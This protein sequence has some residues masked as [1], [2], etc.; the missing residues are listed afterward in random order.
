MKPESIAQTQ[1]LA[2]KR[3]C[4]FMA[5]SF[6][7]CA[8]ASFADPCNWH[9]KEKSES[10]RS[11][12]RI[13]TTLFGRDVFPE[14]TVRS[15]DFRKASP[16]MNEIAVNQ[17]TNI[18]FRSTYI[19]TGPQKFENLGPRIGCQLYGQSEKV[20]FADMPAFP[21]VASPTL[22]L[23][24]FCAKPFE[25]ARLLSSFDASLYHSLGKPYCVEL[26]EPEQHFDPFGL[27]KAAIKDPRRLPPWASSKDL[28]VVVI[29]PPG[30][31]AEQ[32]M[33]D[34][35]AEITRVS[36][37]QCVACY[38]Q[39]DCSK[40]TSVETRRRQTA[41][42]LPVRGR[43]GQIVPLDELKTL[44]FENDI[45][46]LVIRATLKKDRKTVKSESWNVVWARCM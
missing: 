8:Q 23:A 35:E 30:N 34:I 4:L 5:G 46:G 32:Y 26:S 21:P 22:K 10:V 1:A 31:R 38:P 36:D 18:D 19:R 7:I 25:Q 20:D 6:F 24:S 39:A 43:T 28:F 41:V 9:P 45:Y 27:N 15:V 29:A 3:F 37:P 33:L 12:L 42:E 13:G 2:L 14:E 11:V 44:D 40:L 16:E 17:R